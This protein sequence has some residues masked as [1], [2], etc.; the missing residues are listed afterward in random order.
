[1]PLR[2]LLNICLL[3]A[4]PQDLPASRLGMLAALAAYAAAGVLGVLDVL[5]FEN[6]VLAA[7]VD[8][9]LLAAVTHLVLPWRQ[10]ENRVTQTLTALAGC[11]ALLS[12]LAWATSGLTREW[13]PPAWVWAPFL[14]WYT[15]VFGHVWRHAL[16]ITLAAGVAA[17]LLYLILSMGVTGLFM[18]PVPATN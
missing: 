1:M 15:L 16:S 9:L 17:S 6:A 4:S 2:I 10:L 3:R 13:L 11:G 5:T 18:N 7:A 12:L 14:V 8:T